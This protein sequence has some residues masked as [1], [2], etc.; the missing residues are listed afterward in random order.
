VAS[1]LNQRPQRTGPR[2]CEPPQVERRLRVLLLEDDATDAELEVR[3]LTAAGFRVTC[4]RVD[5]ERAFTARLD[6]GA[7]DLILSDYCLPA[8]DGLRA[9]Q[10]LRARGLDVPFVLVSG[11]L[12]EER[13]IESL[14]LGAIDYVLKDNLERL[15]PAIRRALHDTEERRAHARAAAA[16][17]ESEERYRNLVESA[18]EIILTLALDG[19]I[20]SANLTFEVVLG[21]PRATAIGAPF[22][23]LLHPEDRGAAE[24]L[25][26]RVGGGA[27]VAPFE[28]RVAAVDGRRLV[29][30]TTAT[31]QRSATAAA[32]ILVVARDVTARKRAETKMQAL[33]ENA[34][35]LTGTVDLGEVLARVQERSARALPCEVV[36]TVYGG[37]APAERTVSH[38]GVAAD[39]VAGA[40]EL[41]GLPDEAVRAVRHGETLAIADAQADPSPTAAVCRRFR[42]RSALLT[43]LR[44]HDRHFGSLLM[45]DSAPRT[46][47]REEVDFCEAIARQLAGALE[48][49][50]LQR[51]QQEETYI[52]AALAHVGQELISSVDLPLLLERLCRVTTEVLGCDVSHTLMFKEEQHSFVPVACFGEAAGQPATMPTI[53]VPRPAFVQLLELAERNGVVQYEAARHGHLVPQEC[54]DAYR[55]AGALAVRLRRGGELIGVHVAGYRSGPGGFTSFQRRIARGIAQL[56][57]L[58]LENA[59]LVRQL[60]AANRLKSDFVATMSH[61]L[62]TPLNVIIGYNEL[63][64]DEVFGAVTPDQAATLERVGSSARELLE[65]I[66]ATLDVSRLDTERAALNLEHIDL[67]AL[68][69]AVEAETRGLREK[70][71]VEWTWHIAAE[72]PPLYSDAVKLK[73]LLKN[74]IANA[75]KFTDRGSVAVSADGRPGCIEFRVADTGIGMSAETQAVIFEPFRQ[76]D[77]S[78]TR[79]HGGVGLGLYIVSRLLDLLSGRIEVESALGVGSTFRVAVPIDASRPDSPQRTQRPQSPMEWTRAPHHGNGTRR[80]Q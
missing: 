31:V 7:Y 50:E 26:G 53:R 48:A 75:A 49:A 3:A 32:S 23:A 55:L 70:P 14:K 33:V 40:A 69:R 20:T 78:P 64:L 16:L 43:P 42:L 18:Q 36:A 61:E 76:G 62:R 77:S 59:R 9:L 5:N 46:F 54:R 29:F 38:H 57:S 52:A 13:A 24:R 8:F 47:D 41:A 4:D 73:V 17:R 80:F 66:G 60:E 71:G 34:K 10:I 11:A 51:A 6:T 28:F 19:T 21:R 22:A 72:L 37:A 65:L 68:L 27:P 67:A 12:G 30:E 2:D 56:A 1:P 58:A 63:V 79:R 15:A 74:L 44:S 39:L 45:A 25:V 35:D